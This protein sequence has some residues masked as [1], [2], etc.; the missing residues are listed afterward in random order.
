MRCV[1][2]WYWHLDTL[3]ARAHVWFFIRGVARRRARHCG[4][5]TPKR[6]RRRGWMR[7]REAAGAPIS[8]PG[9]PGRETPGPP[10][11]ACA[12]ASSGRVPLTGLRGIRPGLHT[13]LCPGPGY[14]QKTGSCSNLCSCSCITPAFCFILLHRYCMSPPTRGDKA[15][16]TSAGQE[17]FS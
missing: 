7:D 16:A 10:G 3:R 11:I 8:I 1:C 13:G 15:A 6:R 14:C 12:P 2:A 9:A 17:S 4:G 5:R